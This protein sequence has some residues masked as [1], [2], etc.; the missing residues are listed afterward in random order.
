M[1]VVVELGP[2][3]QVRVFT[4]GASEIIIDD[5]SKVRERNGDENEL[6]MNIR[7]NLKNTTLKEMAQKTLRTIAL[8][9][10]DISYD[11]F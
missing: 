3:K 4:K 9:Y 1:T 2:N 10:K 7:E 8:G 6:D 11:E 5:C